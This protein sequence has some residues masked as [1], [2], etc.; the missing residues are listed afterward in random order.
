M[1]DI[2][3]SN[4]MDRQNQTMTWIIIAIIVIV[5]I[6]GIWY[7]AQQG[8][9]TVSVNNTQTQGSQHMITAFSFSTLTPPVQGS[10]DEATHA[11]TVTVPQ[12][13]NVTNLSPTI[14]VSDGASVQPASDTPQDFTNPVIYTVTGSDGTTQEYTVTVIKAAAT[15]SN[16]TTSATGSTIIIANMSYTPA[17]LTVKRGTTVTWMNQDTTTHNVIGDNGGPSSG[18]L[19]SGQN[20]SYTFN[21][22]GTFLYH[23]SIHPSMKGTVIV[24]Q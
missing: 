3:T 13:T 19:V 17:S 14:Q 7:I 11:V 16:T 24:T 5:V 1:A 21:Q 8:T 15:T 12:G 10:I 20:Y 6:L 4:R 23:C 2:N 18:T 22:T 9:N